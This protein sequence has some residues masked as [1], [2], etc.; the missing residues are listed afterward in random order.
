[1]KLGNQ[2][3]RA[4][5]SAAAVSNGWIDM[6]KLLESGGVCCHLAAGKAD[7]AI[8][9]GGAL[10]FELLAAELICEHITGFLYVDFCCSVFRTMEVVQITKKNSN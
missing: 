10:H 1:M 8:P 2:T 7:N 9:L 4:Q 5:K 6:A 3:E